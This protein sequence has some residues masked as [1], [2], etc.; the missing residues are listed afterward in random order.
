MSG[1]LGEQ[2]LTAPVFKAVFCS[3]KLSQVLQ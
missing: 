3:P 1:S 2:D